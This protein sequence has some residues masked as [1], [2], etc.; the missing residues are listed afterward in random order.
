MI[1]KIFVVALLLWPALAHGQETADPPAALPDSVATVT[2]RHEDLFT[3]RG[4]SVLSASDRAANLSAR[5]RELA[6]SPRFDPGDLTV[7]NDDT[8]RAS[9]IAGAGTYVATCWDFEADALGLAH[10]ELAQQRLEIIQSAISSYRSD[11]SAGA[12]LKGAAYAAIATVIFV[13][14]LIILG[15]AKNR[16]ER[17]AETRL[18]DRKVLGLDTSES[19]VTIVKGIVRLARLVTVIWLAMAYVNALLSF[20]P[21]TYGVAAT[22]FELAAGPLRT[23]GQAL[24]DEIPSFFFL[25][26]IFFITRFLLRGIHFVFSEIES[27]HIKIKGFYRDWARPTFNIVRV[28]VILFA[29]MAATPY[30][31]GSNTGAFKGM[32]IFLGV[33]VSLGSSSAMANLVSGLI[34]IY[35]RPFAVGDRVRIGDTVGDVT[36]RSILTTRLMTTKNELV[37]VPN[38]NILGGQIINYTL[39]GKG[40]ELILHTTVTI[41]YD[42]PWRQVHALLT[43]AAEATAH[44]KED[45]E[46]F[47]L[48]TALQDFYISYELNAYTE[49]PRLIPR[50]YS[51]LHQNIQDRFSEAGVEILSPHYRVNR[52]DDQLNPSDTGP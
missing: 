35:M 17:F 38:T 52:G 29:V 51:E 28:L 25:V 31:P 39:K 30:I 1:G 50:T 42:V 47:V 8:L 10:E 40:R 6:D 2:L 19:I 33:L 4:I 48:Q 34:L 9:H 22:V 20:F 7:V 37:T 46:P 32:T 44:V 41:G 16:L 5:I 24:V 11:F 13:V 36:H 15:R 18:K 27:E 3:V 12:I 14:L 43:A 26:F 49:R 21:W 45:P 23:F